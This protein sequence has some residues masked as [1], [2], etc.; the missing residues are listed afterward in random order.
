M[1]L[2]DEEK[3]FEVILALPD[4]AR[5]A[6]ISL[7]G[8]HCEIHNVRV[9]SDLEKVDPQVIPRIAD[10]ISYIRD[11]PVGDI[12][13]VQIDGPR[14]AASEGILIRDE[15]TL[16]FHTMSLPT[17][18]LVWHCPFLVVFASEDGKVNGAGYREYALLR[19]DGESWEADECADDKI[20]V[21]QE[22]SFEG[23]NVWKEKNKQGFDCT[24]EIKHSKN[25]IMIRTENLGISIE[26]I[27]RINDPTEGL[28]VA[29]TGDQCAISNIR[30]K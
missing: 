10:E 1:F 18:R 17:A 2:S 15:M 3:V 28:Y 25:Q 12:P 23:W 11:C 4:T 20:S 22:D 19:L 5:Y 29:L 26:S 16:T 27:V 21:V 9:E 14:L 13:N 7:S 24:V 30:I 8:E 6:Y